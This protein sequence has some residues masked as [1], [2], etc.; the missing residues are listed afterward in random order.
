VP[1]LEFHCWVCPFE[2]QIR[3]KS[4]KGARSRFTCIIGCEFAV[5]NGTKIGKGYTTFSAVG[6]AARLSSP[7]RLRPRRRRRAGAAARG[8]LAAP[9]LPVRVHTAAS[10][11]QLGG[12]E[13]K[14]TGPPRCRRLPSSVDWDSRVRE[15]QMGWGIERER[16]EREARSARRRRRSRAGRGGADWRWRNTSTHHVGWNVEGFGPLGPLLALIK[17]LLIHKAAHVGMPG[18]NFLNTNHRIS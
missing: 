11:A 12:E 17:L 16:P 8:G 10:A 2:L 6:S 7:P 18:T 14:A 4:T 5:S 15:G 3:Y 13:Q 9:R 1:R